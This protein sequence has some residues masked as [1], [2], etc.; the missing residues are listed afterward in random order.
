[1]KN[2]HLHL[3]IVYAINQ[4]EWREVSR[5][6]SITEAL[7]MRDFKQ[8]MNDEAFQRG[9]AHSYNFIIIVDY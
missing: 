6:A 2:K 1:M 7:T 9:E 4:H 5:H 8:K 3:F